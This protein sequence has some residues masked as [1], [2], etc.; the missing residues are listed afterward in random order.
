MYGQR[1]FEMISLSVDK[2]SREDKVQVFLEEQQAAFSNYLYMGEDQGALIDVIDPQGQ[3]VIRYTLLVAPGGKVVY[4]HGG[5]ID[6]LEV[7]KTIISVLGRYY[8][9]D[10]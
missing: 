6:P 10:R 8:A 2:P 5:I 3:G 7:K 9:D 1:K 4:R